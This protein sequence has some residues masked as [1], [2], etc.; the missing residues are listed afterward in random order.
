MLTKLSFNK[1]FTND[2]SRSTDKKKKVFGD[3]IDFI[4]LI[5]GWNDI[6]GTDFG[7]NT[8]PLKISYKTLYILTPHST[9][10][11]QLSFTEHLIV[12]KIITKFPS[13]RNEIRKIRFQVNPNHFLQ[14]TVE[15]EKFILK[16]EKQIIPHRFSPEY[17]VLNKEGEEV[18]Q[19]IDDLELKEQLISIYIQ[20]RFAK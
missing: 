19:D 5:K 8:L 9:Y 10:S 7:K 14:K 13:F 17:K 18:Y 16:K 11:E 2:Q 6:I 1:S 15:R 12:K 3:S 4:Q 20:S